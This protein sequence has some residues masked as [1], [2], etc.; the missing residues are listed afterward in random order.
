MNQINSI[1]GSTNIITGCASGLGRATLLWFLKN[2]CGPVLGIDRRIKSDFTEQLNINDEQK[3]K[4]MLRQHDTFDEGV[5]TSLKEFV[6]KHKHIDN[7][8]NVAGISMA[9]GFY[10]GKSQHDSIA[11]AATMLNFNT[12]GTFNMIRHVAKFMIDDTT[13]REKPKNIINTSCMSTTNPTRHQSF[14]TATKAALDSMTL[15]MAREFAPFHIKCNTINV[16][17]FESSLINPNKELKLA[18]YLANEMT[19]CPKRLGQPE[20]F[21]HLVQAIVENPMLNGACIKIDGAAL[22]PSLYWP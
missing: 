5:E 1:I 13:N 20:E 7:L 21:A 8:I 11:N 22:S 6:D 14:S 16:G 10:N 2:G 18:H 19:L 4:L 15:S 3:S 17:Y 12:V 9:F